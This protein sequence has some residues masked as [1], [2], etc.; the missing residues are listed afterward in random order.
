MK[1]SSY[2]DQVKSKLFLPFREGER[3]RERERQLLLAE[4][5]WIAKV[6]QGRSLLENRISFKDL[7][8]ESS[9]E[10]SLKEAR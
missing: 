6:A 9:L 8:G 2:L 4:L 5:D 3:E 7:R 1:W 10:I